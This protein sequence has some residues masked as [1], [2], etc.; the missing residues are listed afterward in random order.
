M[1][2][3]Y[4]V[5]LRMVTN[6]IILYQPDNTMKLEVRLENETVWLIQQQMAD[7][8]L[9]DRSV[10]TKHINNCRDCKGFYF[11][12]GFQM[13]VYTDWPIRNASSRAG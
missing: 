12:D 5:V 3:N 4:F 13:G 8:F 2:S 7:L 1:L 10:I 11:A 6:E 9:R